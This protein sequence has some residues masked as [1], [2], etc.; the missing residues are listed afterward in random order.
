[1]DQYARTSVKPPEFNETTPPSTAS[2]PG[3]WSITLPGKL[4]DPQLERIHRWLTAPDEATRSKTAASL[5]SKPR[6]VRSNTE[7]ATC[8]TGHETDAGAA[9]CI[10]LSHPVRQQTIP[11]PPNLPYPTRRCEERKRAPCSSTCTL[12][13]VVEAAGPVTG[14]TFEVVLAAPLRRRGVRSPE[15]FCMML[16]GWPPA[17]G[18]VQPFVPSTNKEMNLVNR[19][20]Y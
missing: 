3:P 18:S 17:T 14:V 20:M 1:M 13:V 15:T 12:L 8:D 9:S 4:V 10:R 2:S 19:R 11:D 16:T 6:A 5:A 7:Q